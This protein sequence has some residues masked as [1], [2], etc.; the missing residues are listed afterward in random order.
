MK[1]K[2]FSVKMGEVRVHALFTVTDVPTFL[3]AAQ[4]MIDATQV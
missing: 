4:P 1:Y 3:A 2:G